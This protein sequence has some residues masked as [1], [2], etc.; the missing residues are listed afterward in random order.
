MSHSE[1]EDGMGPSKEELRQEAVLALLT[2]AEALLDLVVSEPPGNETMGI[3]RRAR[4]L[5]HEARQIAKWG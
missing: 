5:V 2:K 3:I 1:I 4:A